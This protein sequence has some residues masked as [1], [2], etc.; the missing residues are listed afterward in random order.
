MPWDVRLADRGGRADYKSE[1]QCKKT[2]FAF[3]QAVRDLLAVWALEDMRTME[4]F[5]WE[6]DGRACAYSPSEALLYALVH[7]HQ[8]Y[9]RYLL[10]R[11]SVGA[12][13]MPSKSFRCCPSSC[14]PHLAMAVRYNRLAILQMILAAAK[15]FPEGERLGY[16]NRR[17]CAHLE[18]GKTPLHLA[19]EL[20]RPEC[21]LM[22]LG[23]AAS[24]CVTDRDGNT[25][26][27]SLLAHIGHSE[28]DLRLKRV[29]LGYLVLFMPEPRFQTRGHLLDSPQRWRALLGEQGYQWLCGSAPPSLCVRAMQ[30]LIRSVPPEE[31][32]SLPLPD[33]L[34]PL[35]FRLQ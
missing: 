23:S 34:K 16:V 7:D 24:P 1:K 6:E 35:D 15:H 10:S 22:L 30:T 19:C 2:S 20:G 27:D 9:A 17:G 12:L 11:F 13:E 8:P 32:D 29:C 33:F 28:L 25:P 4:V 21:L 3:Y 26:L 31:L 5:H 14:T 18:A